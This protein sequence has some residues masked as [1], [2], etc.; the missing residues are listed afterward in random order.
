MKYPDPWPGRIR[1]M[2][3]AIGFVILTVGC[4]LLSNDACE[5][6]S[7]SSYVSSTP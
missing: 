1:V 4:G 5:V 3:L 7:L 6:L 2:G